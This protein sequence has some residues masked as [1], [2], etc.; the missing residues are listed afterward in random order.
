MFAG[1]RLGFVGVTREHGAHE[2]ALLI[3]AGR[4]ALGEVEGTT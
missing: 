2:A 4:E 3:E 1:G